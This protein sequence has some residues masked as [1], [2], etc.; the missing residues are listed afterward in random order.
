VDYDL[1]L[2]KTGPRTLEPL[3]DIP[4]K[5]TVGNQGNVPSR[6]Y[7]VTDTAPRASSS[8]RPATPV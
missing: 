3:A 4:F 2:V 5:V 8:P 7:E 6:A 1:A